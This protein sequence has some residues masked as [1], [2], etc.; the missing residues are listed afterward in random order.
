MAELSNLSKSFEGYSN[1]YVGSLCIEDSANNSAFKS[2]YG[3]TSVPVH[4]NYDNGT[5]L[6]TNN[7]YL[8]FSDGDNYSIR[9]PSVNNKGYL[10]QESRHPQTKPIQ[11]TCDTGWIPFGNR[12]VMKYEAS[13]DGTTNCTNAAGTAAACPVSNTTTTPWAINQANAKAACESIGA[14]LITNAEWM[15]IARDIE[16]T[17]SNWSG[18]VLNRG[19]TD[20]VPPN[21]LAASTDNDPYYGTGQTTG[22]QKRTHTLSNGEVI[23]D[24]AGN[25]WDWVDDKIQCNTTVC[26]STLMPYDTTP[27]SEWIDYTNVS[28]WGKYSR[29]ELGVLG[30]FTGATNSVGR[31][32][33]D[34]DAAHPSGTIHSFGRGGD[35]SNTSNGGVFALFLNTSPSRSDGYFGFRCAR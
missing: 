9:T 8:Y 10:I 23:W 32:Y 4:P 20:N 15:A 12:C 22:E 11:K 34:A 27:G 35:W 21:A 24:F 28:T 26:P 16:A 5:S 2:Y 17:T 7:C 25:V 19:H 31:I 6:T 29:A 30:A 1:Y 3:L 13:S 18:T 14:H 33:V